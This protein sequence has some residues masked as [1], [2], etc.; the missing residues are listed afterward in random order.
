MR[1]RKDHHETEFKTSVQMSDMSLPLNIFTGQ[2]KPSVQTWCQQSGK[3]SPPAEDP[4][5]EHKH[6]EQYYN[7]PEPSQQNVLSAGR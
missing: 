1:E 5:R 2:G 6:F 3:Y 4:G 7:L